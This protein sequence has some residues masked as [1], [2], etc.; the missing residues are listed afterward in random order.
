LDSKSE[1]G[2]DEGPLHEDEWRI[3]SEEEYVPT[4][5]QCQVT[6]GDQ[7][8]YESAPKTDG[9]GSE[10]VAKEES[11]ISFNDLMKQMKRM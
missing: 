8:A 1:D 4:T 10:S 11:S 6:E 7:L 3:T 9:A 5:E 2:A